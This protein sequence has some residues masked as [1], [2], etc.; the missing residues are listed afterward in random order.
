MVWPSETSLRIKFK[1]LEIGGRGIVPN[2]TACM[3]SSPDIESR[4]S[5][6]GKSEEEVTSVIVGPQKLPEP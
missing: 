4:V 6:S 3:N 2:L 5:R 1:T